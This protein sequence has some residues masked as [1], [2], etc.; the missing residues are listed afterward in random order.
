[1]TVRETP[2][3]T[4]GGPGLTN[5]RLLVGLVGS[6]EHRAVSRCPDMARLSDHYLDMFFVVD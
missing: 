6:G 5:E 2:R 3:R 1:M 4:E